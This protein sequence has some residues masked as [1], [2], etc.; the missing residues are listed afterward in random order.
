MSSQ[1]SYTYKDLIAE[2]G[3]T[4]DSSSWYL[5]LTSDS[6]ITEAFGVEVIPVV[7]RDNKEDESKTID[8]DVLDMSSDE[9]STP[10]DLSRRVLSYIRERKAKDPEY[11]P[12]DEL[13]DPDSS[14][15]TWS[16]QIIL[17]I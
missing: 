11:D 6:R 13:I 7:L 14:S 8:A 2:Y 10:N 5:H 15:T 3:N 12:Y 4:V 1:S 16:R 9:R 17:K